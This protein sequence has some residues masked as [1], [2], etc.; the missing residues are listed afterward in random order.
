MTREGSTG[1]PKV[2]KLTHEVALQSTY[3]TREL[4]YIQCFRRSSNFMI[5]VLGAHDFCHE[6]LGCQSLPMFH[7]LGLI[8]IVQA[9]NITLL[10]RSI[11]F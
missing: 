8:V 10:S 3:A 7:G 11:A 2:V 6:I 5:L 1:F 9:V 4:K